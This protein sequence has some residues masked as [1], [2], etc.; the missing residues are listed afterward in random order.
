MN[1]NNLTHNKTINKN[2]TYFFHIKKSDISN[3][4]DLD[5]IKK[6]I[7]KSDIDISNLKIINKSDLINISYKNIGKYLKSNKDS[8]C[9]DCK[10]TIK[11]TTIF[12]EL[13]CKHRFH[14]LCI[15]N[16]LHNDVYKKCTSCNTENI[17]TNI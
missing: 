6:L 1:E 8:V 10:T 12:K 15:D 2:K 14:T 4:N 13:N 16:K 11:A 3:I 9:Q 17:S 7:N 5:S